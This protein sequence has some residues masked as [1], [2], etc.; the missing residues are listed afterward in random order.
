[1]TPAASGVGPVS[2]FQAPG[3]GSQI[4]DLWP[5]G[6]NLLAAMLY[7]TSSKEWAVAG[8]IVVGIDGSSDG[9]R[10][11]TWA[12]D[13]ARKR[14]A[15]LVVVHAWE[16]PAATFAFPIDSEASASEVLSRSLSEVDSHDVEVRKRLVEGRPVNALVR[17]AIDA[18]MLVV[19]SR[20]HS[21][22]AAVILGSVSTACVHHATCPVVVV[23]PP[24]GVPATHHP[25]GATT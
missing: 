12:L 15:E 11:L 1:M 10:A 2:H 19:G 14:S 13:E 20:G 18:D 17:E 6:G 7:L 4:R 23:P 24:R 25:A 8:R 3:R 9:Q 22:V 16:Y 5:W 21:G